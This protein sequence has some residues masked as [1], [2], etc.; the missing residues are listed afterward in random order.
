LDVEVNQPSEIFI[1]QEHGRLVEATETDHAVGTEELRC[2][3]EGC[4]SATAKTSGVAGRW[5]GSHSL[6]AASHF[7]VGDVLPALGS[8]I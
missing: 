1:V 4:G 8:Y 3:V 6:G 7:L 5:L 2:P